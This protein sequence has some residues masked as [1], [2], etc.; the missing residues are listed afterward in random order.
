M[1]SGNS[2]EPPSGVDK[3]TLE[4]MKIA[5]KIG[6]ESFEENTQILRKMAWRGVRAFLVCGFGVAAFGYAMRR[7]RMYEEMKR[8]QALEEEPTQRYLEEMRGLGFDVDTLEEELEAERRA[9][10][11]K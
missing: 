7:R 6:A 5:E 2:K 10:Q 4:N 11:L 1:V 8:A 3:R 9:K